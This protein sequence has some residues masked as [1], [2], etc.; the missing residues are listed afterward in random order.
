MVY[1]ISEDIINR[2]DAKLIIQSIMELVLL[3]LLIYVKRKILI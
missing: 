3:M 1:G 2:V